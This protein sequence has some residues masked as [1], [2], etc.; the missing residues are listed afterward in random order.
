LVSGSACT[1][2]ATIRPLI[3]KASLVRTAPVVVLRAVA[4]VVVD[5]PVR[6]LECEFR[7]NDAVRHQENRAQFLIEID[8]S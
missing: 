4:D 6:T 5:L 7:L 1:A 8:R 2:A 3:A